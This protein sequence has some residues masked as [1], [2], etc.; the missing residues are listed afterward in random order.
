[1]GNFYCTN[2]FKRNLQL[3]HIEFLL[4]LM[5]TILCWI[6]HT[7]IGLDASK[8]MILMFKLKGTLVHW[9]SLKTKNWR[10]YFMKTQVP[11]KLA[12]SLEVDHWTVLKCLKLLEMIRKPGHRVLY[13]LKP[14][15]IKQRLVTCEQRLQC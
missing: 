11:A 15:D 7:E 12:E 14:R 13:K 4:R 6:Q 8:I 5:T 1:M 9:K 10:H 2:S 3:K